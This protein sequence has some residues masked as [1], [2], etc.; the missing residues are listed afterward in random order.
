MSYDFSAF[1]PADVAVPADF[2]PADVV[3]TSPVY[4][5]ELCSTPQ[6]VGWKLG[7]TNPETGRRSKVPLDL[8]AQP[9]QKNYAS[10]A[11][12]SH[13]VAFEV[14][15]EALRR[16]KFGTQGIGFV[17]TKDD[18]YCFIDLDNCILPDGSLTPEAA[19]VASLMTGTYAET[20][21]SGTGLH[22][23]CIAKLSSKV[24]TGAIDIYPHSQYCA[25]TGKVYGGVYPIV[26][27][28]HEVEKLAA[29]L[30]RGANPPPSV[31]NSGSIALGDSELLN[32]AHNATNGALFGSLWRGDTNG[33]GGDHSRADNALLMLL[34]YWT[35]G[36]IG[37]TDALFRQSGLM[38]DKWDE[39][40]YADGRTYGAGS[41]DN[42]VK[43]WDGVG[44]SGG[45][46]GDLEHGRQVAASLMAGM[47]SLGGGYTEP[48]AQ[49]IPDAEPEAQ[50][51]PEAAQP[52]PVK[53]NPD[54]PQYLSFAELAAMTFA[55]P[56][57]ILPDILPDAG[58]YLLS[59]KPKCGKSWLALSLALSVTTGG[60][61]LGRKVQQGRVMYLA[62]EDTPRRFMQRMHKIQPDCLMNPAIKAAFENGMFTPTFPKL[63]RGFEATI[64]EAITGAGVRLLIIDTLAK[65][66][67]IGGGNA[68]RYDADYGAVGG[69]KD[70][71]DRFGICVL[72][73]HHTRKA[74]ADDVHDTVSGTNGI[75]GAADGSLVLL[76]QRGGDGSA[77]LAVTGRD[78]PEAEFGLRFK[79][80]FWE[81]I[82]NAEEVKAGVE[83]NA[84]F[85]ALKGYGSD[86]ATVKTLCCEVNKNP[87]AVKFLL[88][89]L[90]DAGRV[91]VRNTKP[92]PHYAIC[93]GSASPETDEEAFTG[94]GVYPSPPPNM[95]D[96][97]DRV[98]TLD[99]LDTLD[100]PPDEVGINPINL[101]VDTPET[102]PAIKGINPINLD[103]DTPLTRLAS[104]DSPPPIK[105]IKGIN[106]TRINPIEGRIL[107]ALGGQPGGMDLAT[108]AKVAT[109]KAGEALFK[110]TVD[111]MLLRGAIGRRGDRYLP[112]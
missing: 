73:L 78:L 95:V 86:G 52:Q 35:N 2:V 74:E 41:I 93:D 70:I 57:W 66:R 26:D 20:S 72:V 69:L 112:V 27:K 85:S 90:V 54:A 84:I 97:L 44:F 94:G 42:A 107:D 104:S 39:K 49:P 18:P 80:G 48:E 109:G 87:P 9:G 11:N 10:T 71:A 79:E 14:A 82:G 108:L 64:E 62:L 103:V 46:G 92:A 67:P 83:Q 5:P 91:R 7:D 8:N 98:D 56:S 101:D 88:R 37:R 102:E 40:H 28:Q 106:Q 32:I 30:R 4:P 23:I 25:L 36:D 21:Q 22:Y 63:G 6:F 96:T 47:R 16:G 110:K 65:I 24:A 29:M 33:H 53:R 13:H 45:N 34:L 50:P 15:T 1:V 55:E 60:H 51:I 76:R 75:S 59:G 105:G 43:K 12:P 38:R 81:F 99:T 111:A 61:C 19:D 89:K 17:F 68:N 58:L 31:S 77:T 3:P 100:T